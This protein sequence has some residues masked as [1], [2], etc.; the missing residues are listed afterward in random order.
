MHCVHEEANFIG[1]FVPTSIA[2]YFDFQSRSSY[3]ILK[4]QH[5]DENIS[6]FSV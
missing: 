1:Q 4:S 3:V 5:A 2:K 6:L